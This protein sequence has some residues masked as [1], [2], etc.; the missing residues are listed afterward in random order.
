V[1]GAGSAAVVVVGGGV[2]VIL[3]RLSHGPAITLTYDFGRNILTRFRSG[4]HWLEICQ[5]RYSKT[6]RD[7]RCCPNCIG[8]VEDEHHALFDCPIYDDLREKF[9]DLFHDECRTLGE[10]V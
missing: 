6:P 1:F 3:F 5:G 7:M 10:A 8:V 2:V 9:S 4:Y